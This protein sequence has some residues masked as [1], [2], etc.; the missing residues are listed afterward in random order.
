MAGG[1]L[2]SIF[3][4]HPLRLVSEALMRGWVGA[5]SICK[6]HGSFA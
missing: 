4:T 2:Q 1:Y 3:P 5:A 6:S